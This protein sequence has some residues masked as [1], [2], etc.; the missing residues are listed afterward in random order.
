MPTL[1]LQPPP[2]SSW[3][4][5]AKHGSC[6]EL[7]TSKSRWEPADSWPMSTP[8]YPLPASACFHHPYRGQCPERASSRGGRTALPALELKSCTK[9]PG[10]LSPSKEQ[11]DDMQEG[12][13][14][15]LN[16]STLR[17]ATTSIKH[18]PAH[19]MHNHTAQ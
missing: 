4:V 12:G 19:Y 16:Q 15:N 14:L 6:W 3:C 18:Q 11:P 7:R 17:P 9:A 13:S 2:H 1:R 5:Q 10:A 8:L